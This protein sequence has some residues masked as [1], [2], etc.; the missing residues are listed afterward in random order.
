MKNIVKVAFIAIA[1][2][3]A[4]IIA[5]PIPAMAAVDFSISLGN[6]AFAYTDGYWDRDHHW[7]PW[8]RDYCMVRCPI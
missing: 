6:V 4:P 3:G 7:H 8:R 5:A 2:A 1:L